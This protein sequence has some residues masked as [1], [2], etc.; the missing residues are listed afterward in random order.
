VQESRSPLAQAHLLPY[1]SLRLAEVLASDGDRP[2]ALVQAEEARR[3]ATE[4]G[5]GLIVARVGELER[6]VGLPASGA[7]SALATTPVRDNRVLLTERERQV[8]ALVE[9]GQSNRQVAQQLFISAKT[10]S[11]HVSSILRKLGATSRTEAV[12]LAHQGETA[13]LTPAPH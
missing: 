13:E 4:I 3:R 6:R 11:V 10:A 5:A 2:A 1:S 7:A 9:Q 12:F 8:L